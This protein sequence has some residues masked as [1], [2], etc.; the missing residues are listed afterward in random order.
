MHAF[1]AKAKKEGI[2]ASCTELKPGEIELAGEIPIQ[3]SVISITSGFSREKRKAE[4]K[5][6]LVQKG[7]NSVQ[8]PPASTGRKE[9]PKKNGL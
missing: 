3:S 2:T 9:K 7:R 8:L 5:R 1:S 4:E 6:A